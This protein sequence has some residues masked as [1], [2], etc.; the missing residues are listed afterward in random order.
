[1][2]AS[3]SDVHAGDDLGDPRNTTIG[4]STQSDLVGSSMRVMEHE[5]QRSL[6]AHPRALG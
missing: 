2:A 4:D 6:P 1:M 5:P 3:S